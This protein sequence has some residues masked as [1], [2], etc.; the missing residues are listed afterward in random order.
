MGPALA[1][2]I[3]AYFVIILSASAGAGWALMRRERKGTLS[4]IG[5]VALMITTATMTTVGVAEVTNHFLQLQESTQNFLLPVVAL[6]IAGVGQDWVKVVPWLA[7]TIVAIIMAV[8]G[9]GGN[10][11]PWQGR[12]RGRPSFKVSEDEDTGALRDEES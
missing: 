6:L 2:V 4:A 3:G 12:P 1:H 10:T 9:G 7:N 11:S 8:K 5:F